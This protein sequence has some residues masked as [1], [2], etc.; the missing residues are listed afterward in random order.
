MGEQEIKILI[1]VFC[2]LG[3]VIALGGLFIVVQVMLMHYGILGY[4]SKQNQNQK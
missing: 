4:L 1:I 3:I 2:V